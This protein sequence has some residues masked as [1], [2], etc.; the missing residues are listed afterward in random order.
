MGLWVDAFG[1]RPLVT[2]ALGLHIV[3]A[4]GN[5]LQLFGTKQTH[6]IILQ[7]P[8]NDLI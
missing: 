3:G 7:T 6:A 8:A 1:H 4:F 5:P 2:A